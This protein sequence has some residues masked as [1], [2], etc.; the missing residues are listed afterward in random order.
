MNGR[1]ESGVRSQESGRGNPHLP[2]SSL[3]SPSSASLRLCVNLF[4][5]GALLPPLTAQDLTI[6]ANVR[7][8]IV[9]LNQQFV[10]NV[11]VTGNL[12][13]ASQPELPDIGSFA[14]YVSSGSSTRFEF[15]NGR[16]TSS[17]TYQ[18]SFLATQEGK[19]EIG[20]VTLR[21]GS[22]EYKTEPVQIT[23]AKA[24]A[25][26]SRGRSSGPSP[27]LR[28]DRRDPAS[29]GVSEDELF[30]QVNANKR[31][32]YQGEPVI[33]EYKLYTQVNVTSFSVL[34]APGTAGFW[35]EDFELPSSPVPHR[36]AREGR[37]YTVATL[38]KTAL[39]PTSPG[40]KT[41]DPMVLEC[42]VRVLRPS[43]RDP[44]DIDRFFRNR[45][46]FGGGRFPMTVVSKPLEI[47]VLPF[48]D[49][50]R[51]SDFTGISGD[52]RV[53]SSLDKTQVRTNDAVTL[54]VRVSG[55]GNLSALGEPEIGFPDAFEVYPPKLSGKTEWQ[56]ERIT[57]WRSFEYVL[58][59]RAPGTH[60]IPPISMSYFDPASRSYR[61]ARTDEL[62]LLAEGEAIPAAAGRSRGEI[63]QLAQDIR[64]IKTDLPSFQPHG[65]AFYQA[66]AFW[67][68]T[69]LPL[70][71]LAGAL[72]YRRHLDRLL[73]DEAYARKRRASRL[74]KKRLAQARSLLDPG[75]Q[76]EF[77]AETGHALLGFLG[78][79][80]N[81]AEAGLISDQAR[82]LL[83]EKG[84]SQEL[85]DD[86]LDCLQTCD[87]QRFAPSEATQQEMSDFLDR[88][89]QSMTQ[90][91]K[92]VR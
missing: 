26:S 17:L 48:P 55:E 13:Q 75:Q 24:P 10:L 65:M 73:G 54:K 69:L 68:V 12:Q 31:Q 9:G 80:L 51:P 79:K 92:E 88:A 85:I 61:T 1:Q 49:E 58:I 7:P 52:L 35:A 47:D 28:M 91:D 50:G 53:T 83:Q 25:G 19:F 36:E 22:Q 18:Y 89:A 32:V 78:D 71:A 15:I 87:R 64:F 63:R 62:R 4:L 82:S 60:V 70:A 56:G 86:Y 8:E 41:V 59:P 46:L 42:E 16:A 33:V 2:S 45:S 20:P 67:L 29:A 34:T 57:G 11:E 76:K 40:K 77:Y 38:K 5:F 21:Q 84:A 90:L 74:A 44:F 3:S 14:R 6:S 39:F 43:R 37:L 23:V 81:I 27:G 66:P 30:L 72:G